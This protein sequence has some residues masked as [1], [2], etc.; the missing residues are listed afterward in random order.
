ML[1]LRTLGLLVILDVFYLGA[2]IL[3]QGKATSDQPDSSDLSSPQTLDRI[4]LKD[5]MLMQ[6]VPEHNQ[7]IKLVIDQDIPKN[8]STVHS[9]LNPITKQRLDVS[10]INPNNAEVLQLNSLID[11]IPSDN[12]LE[13]SSS[14][15]VDSKPLLVFPSLI[16]EKPVCLLRNRSTSFRI[17]KDFLLDAKDTETDSTFNASD[18]LII[19]EKAVPSICKLSF[20]LHEPMLK[21]RESINDEQELCKNGGI[22]IH[23]QENENTEGHK[24]CN[25]QKRFHIFPFEKDAIRIAMPNNQLDVSRNDFNF[26]VRQINCPNHHSMTDL[27]QD[28]SSHPDNHDT[29]EGENWEN[30]NALARSNLPLDCNQVIDQEEFVL[31]SPNYPSK[32][33]NN[34]DCT[35][36]VYPSSN[37]ICALG[38]LT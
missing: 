15:D 28:R 37:N 29:R 22:Q 23:T 26:T 10:K 36:I 14:D 24:I 8:T 21:D 9:I 13:S 11:E 16:N 19:V 1:G 33:P 32:Y 2:S 20:E 25:F 31:Q 7:I 4:R 5:L 30:E 17:D 12:Q 3:S 18:C 27:M 34:V 38:K 6:T 35:T